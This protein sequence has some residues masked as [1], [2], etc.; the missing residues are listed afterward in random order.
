MSA[1]ISP[2]LAPHG[3]AAGW[4][5]PIVGLALLGL[6]ISLSAM[7]VKVDTAAAQVGVRRA[8]GLEVN[9]GR[10]IR[11]PNPAKVVFIAN[12]KIADIQV[13]SPTLVYLFAKKVGE[14]TLIA[15]DGEEKVLINALVSVNHNLSR[16]R[17]TIRAVLPQRGI[18]IRSVDGSIVL[19]GKVESPTEA[20]K[21]VELAVRVAGDSKQVVNQLKVVGPNQ[22]NLRV[23]VVEMSRQA[24]RQLGINWDALM[25][26][27]T[28]ILQ[29]ATGLATT[30]S[31][32]FPPATPFALRRTINQRTSNSLGLN[33]RSGPYNVNA[34]IDA[35]ETEGLIKVL[36]EPNLTALT[37]KSANFLA[38]GEFP[39]PVPQ[40]GGAIGI[41][42]KKFGV[43]LAFIPVIH[44]G[45]R[46]SLRV[47]TEV[48]QLS[49]A[50]AI[51]LQGTSIPALT[52]RRAET[53]VDVSSGQSFAIAGLLQNNV[54]K[55]LSKVPWLGDVPVVGRLFTSEQFQRNETELVII[56]TPYVVRPGARRQI[57]RAA[58]RAAHMDIKRIV[59]GRKKGRKVTSPKRLVGPAGFILE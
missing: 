23:R 35:L 56:V 52:T 17:R 19:A 16:L 33:Y 6:V 39:I 1:N 15:V 41:E 18:K 43:E 42:F 55:D 32:A 5:W 53:S 37:G 22:V 13:K 8:Y 4:R 12:P 47:R 28:M 20:A 27:G 38:G 21:A 57:A 14:T 58:N 36:A 10:L 9:K 59:L 45:K 25:Q 51:T 34:V 30:A 50:G 11:L 26:R 7:A 44:S 3:V 54:T 31:G 48:S 24:M 29:A 49:T 2:H 40:D 46:I